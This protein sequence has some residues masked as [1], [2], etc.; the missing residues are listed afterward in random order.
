MNKPD[1]MTAADFRAIRQASDADVKA[2]AEAETKTIVIFRRWA[3]GD[4]IA[5]FPEVPGTRYLCS[6]YERIGQHGA[7]DPTVVI[8]A[9]SPASPAEYAAMKAELQSEPYCYRLAPRKRCTQAMFLARQA[10]LNR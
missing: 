10:E 2:Q 7:A 1:N 9:T 6:A 4:V 3:N 5:L 8:A